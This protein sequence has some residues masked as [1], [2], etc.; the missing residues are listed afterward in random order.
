MYYYQQELYHFGIKRRSGRYPYGSGARPYQ[1]REERR[2]RKNLEVGTERLNKRIERAN[3]LA[4]VDRLSS[5]IGWENTKKAAKAHEGIKNIKQ[6]SSEILSDEKRTEKL[7][8]YTRRVRMWDIALSSVG[9]TAAFGGTAFLTTV[10]GA[11]AVGSLALGSIPAAA[12]AAVG[13]NY[14]QKTKY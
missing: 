10:L 7:G 5:R 14:F 9:S 2:R 12:I 1:D 13:Y 3:E 8:E 6:I 11:S 4:D